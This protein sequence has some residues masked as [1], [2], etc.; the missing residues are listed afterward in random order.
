MLLFLIIYLFSIM[1]C[2]FLG[3]NDPARFG[4]VPVAMLSLFQVSTL[5]SWTSIA[6]TSW[7]GCENYIGAPY[8]GSFLT[9]SEYEA[10]AAEGGLWS[11]ESKGRWLWGHPSVVHESIVPTMAGDFQGF[12]CYKEKPAPALTFLF[13]S[14]YIVLTSWV[15]MSLFIGVIS[16]GMVS[17]SS[18][19][20]RVQKLV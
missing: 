7:Y 14:I 9:D 10:P 11:A 2:L 16:M 18:F 17:S 4:T 5:A 1:G 6:Y 3:E 13:F 20:R 8:A 15:I 12:R 19:W